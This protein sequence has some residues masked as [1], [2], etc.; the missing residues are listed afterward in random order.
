MAVV[1]KS[2]ENRTENVLMIA[3]DEKRAKACMKNENNHEVKTF[4]HMLIKMPVQSHRVLVRWR[5]IDAINFFLFF[6]FFA[7]TAFSLSAT[8]N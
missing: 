5:Q 8:L 4:P 2:A 3:K 7:F 6:F 1:L